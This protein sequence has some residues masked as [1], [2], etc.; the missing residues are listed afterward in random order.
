MRL[1]YCFCQG[2]G[3]AIAARSTGLSTKTVRSVYLALRQR[4]LK[5]AFDRWHG[6][7]RM[8]LRLLGPEYEVMVRAGYFDL[9]ARCAGNENCA[10]NF[11]LGNRKERRCR[12]CPLAAV[13]QDD[14]LA[15]V[16]TVIDTVHLFL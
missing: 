14:L 16:Y 2:I 12:R 9:L 3:I 11:R 4:L 10:R 5:P 15:E 1:V 7:N 8:M 13:W 6:T